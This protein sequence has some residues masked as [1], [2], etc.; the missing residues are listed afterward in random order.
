MGMLNY[1]SELDLH[2]SQV[3]YRLNSSDDILE[4]SIRSH[5]H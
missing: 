3:V 4:I 2:P 5:Y 1:C